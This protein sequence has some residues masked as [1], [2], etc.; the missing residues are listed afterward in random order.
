MRGQ[1]LVATFLVAILF[2]GLFLGIV[3]LPAEEIPTAPQLPATQ[4]PSGGEA[5]EVADLI[6][7]LDAEEFDVRQQASSKLAEIGSPAL[8]Q[9]Q[10]AAQSDS[11]EVTSRAIQILEQWMAAPQNELRNQAKAALEQIVQDGSPSAARRA[12]KVLE[13][14]ASDQVARGRN[15]FALPGGVRV[16]VQMRAI[17]AGAGQRKIRAMADGRSIEIDIDQNGKIEMSITEKK[18]GKDVTE[19]FKAD[20]AD[21]LKKNHPA[22]HEIYEKY[23]GKPRVQLVP[24]RAVP[25]AQRA[26]DLQ[27]DVLE[28]QIEQFEKASDKLP[29]FKETVEKLKERLKQLQAE[30]FAEEA[31]DKAE[32]E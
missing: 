16:Q 24:Q 6:A 32:D 18:N 12:E 31:G 8:E 20:S 25:P 4:G 15:L 23:A 26:R 5:G 2:L 17:Q 28:R 11:L 9:V 29:Q 27:I 30:K 3:P 19:K 14:S 13:T 10:Q 7:Q 1:S 21:D 22:A